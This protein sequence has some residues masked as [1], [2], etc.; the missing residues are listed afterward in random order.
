M[1]DINL[2][3]VENPVI[4][5]FIQDQAKFP[6]NFKLNICEDDEMYLFSLNNVKDDRDRALVRY[7]SIGR[8]ILDTVKQ[9]VEWHFGSFEN[10]PSFL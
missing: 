9:V 5:A 7:Y 1:N 10:V 6:E 8:R 3:L 4:K 2:D